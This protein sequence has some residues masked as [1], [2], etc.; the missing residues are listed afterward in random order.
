MRKVFIDTDI[1]LDLL[2]A[3][4]PHYIH[5]AKLFT[6][7]NEGK[8]KGFVSSLIF[9][10]LYYI[11]RKQLSHKKAIEI[12]KKLKAQVKILPVDEAIVKLSLASDFKDF[13][14]A[15]QYYTAKRNRVGCILTRNTKDYVKASISVMS[16][17]DFLFKKGCSYE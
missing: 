2:T 5:S 11:L 9:S 15:I 3:R 8:L 4:E 17:E 14:D 7:L 13:E 16:A 12:L 1:V 6:L 10:N